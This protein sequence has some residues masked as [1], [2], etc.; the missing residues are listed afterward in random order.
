M[1]FEMIFRAK[2]CFQN[3]CSALIPSEGLSLDAS[4]ALLSHENFDG[5]SKVSRI[6]KMEYE[7]IYNL[8]G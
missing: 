4:R 6:D 1:S 7:W 5:K 2:S 8:E 3:F